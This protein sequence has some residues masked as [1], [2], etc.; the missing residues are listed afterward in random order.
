MLHLGMLER[1]YSLLCICDNGVQYASVIT[2]SV[3]NTVCNNDGTHIIVYTDI[4]ELGFHAVTE[5]VII[6]YGSSP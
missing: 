2:M 3:I 5:A 4:G 6:S 1:M